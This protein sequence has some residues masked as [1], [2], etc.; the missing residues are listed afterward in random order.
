MAAHVELIMSKSNKVSAAVAETVATAQVEHV[1]TVGE[2]GSLAYSATR[3]G[4][5]AAAVARKLW[6]VKFPEL[7]PSSSE[8]VQF[9]AAVLNAWMAKNEQHVTKVVRK[10]GEYHILAEGEQVDPAMVT[11][12]TPAY[13]MA[14]EGNAL[15]K[16]KRETP[17]LGAIVEREKKYYQGVYAD[18]WRNLCDSLARLIKSETDPASRASNRIAPFSDRLP[19]LVEKIQTAN[20]AAFNRGE[21]GAY[22]PEKMDRALAAFARELK[23]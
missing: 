6:G 15:T 19:K 23:K 21:T 1:P 20:E 13:V 14:Y 10:M 2:L 5:D 3:G 18:T 7:K 22:E 16:L 9:N 11:T 8:R 17:T 12:L 4:M